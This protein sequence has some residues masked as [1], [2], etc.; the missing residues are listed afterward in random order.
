[1]RI[2]LKKTLCLIITALFIFLILPYSADITASSFSG[3]DSHNGYLYYV[4][5]GDFSVSI[6]YNNTNAK[7]T[8]DDQILNTACFDRCLTLLCTTK[9]FNYSVYTYDTD[10]GSLDYYVTEL[11][12]DLNSPVFACDKHG[13]ICILNNKDKRIIDIITNGT[14]TSECLPSVAYQLMYT[15]SEDFLVFAADGVYSL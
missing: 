3:K 12:A 2:H 8:I 11:S 5:Q 9:N 10:K 7:V 1:M 15:G 13:N 14:E 6:R 4:E